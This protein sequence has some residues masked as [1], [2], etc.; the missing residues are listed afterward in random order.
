MSLPVSAPR[1]A[2]EIALSEAPDKPFRLL[3]AV[4]DDNEH[5]WT[6]GA[7]GELCFL[8]CQTCAHYIHPPQPVCPECLGRDLAPEAVSGRAHVHTWTVNYHPWI[9]GFDPPYVVAIVAIVEQPSVRLTT[10]I[11]NCDV[12]AVE[13]GL[14]VRVVFDPREDGIFIPLFELDSAG[15]AEAGET[16]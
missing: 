2:T 12:D 4:G 10:N 13:I 6:S 15:D 7:R 3:P 16:R 11:V 5:F 8:R 1:R 9:P 14:A